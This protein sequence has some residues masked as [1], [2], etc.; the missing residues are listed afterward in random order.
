[1]VPVQASLSV[2]MGQRAP[3]RAGVTEDVSQRVQR[4]DDLAGGRRQ[5]GGRP[6]DEEG[7]ARG[8][9]P[10]RQQDRHANVA[11]RGDGWG[12]SER[13]WGRDGSHDHGADRERDRDRRALGP[14]GQ[15]GHERGGVRDG[16]ERRG[17]YDRDARDSRERD[18]GRPRDGWSGRASD[19][20]GRSGG[21][22]GRERDWREGRDAA[23]DR[24]RDRGRPASSVFGRSAA[25]VFGKCK[26]PEKAADG[27]DKIYGEAGGS[28]GYTAPIGQAEEVVRIGRRR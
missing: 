3:N 24:D 10:D 11:A 20:G 8:G 23:Q 13:P 15:S 26:V 4:R 7:H 27:L 16:R 6:R 28:V 17:G 14:N 1:M 19:R 12:A 18:G 25:D 2:A 22:H 5:G 9:E 21:R